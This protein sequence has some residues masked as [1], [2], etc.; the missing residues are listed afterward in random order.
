MA[1]SFSKRAASILPSNFSYDAW[2]PLYAEIEQTIQTYRINLLL[3][4]SKQSADYFEAL[5]IK[6]S[7]LA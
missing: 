5:G 4:A 6:I 1:A 7:G 2:Q 3:T